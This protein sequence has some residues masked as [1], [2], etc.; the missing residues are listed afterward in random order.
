MNIPSDIS[1][2]DREI[3]LTAYFM[4][5]IEAMRLNKP[6]N[7][8]TYCGFFAGYFE[9]YGAYIKGSKEWVQKYCRHWHDHF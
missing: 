7:P 6:S 1:D 5:A 9:Y 3:Y 4:C 2:S 8:D